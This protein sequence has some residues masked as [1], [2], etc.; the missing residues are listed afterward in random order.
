MRVLIL[1]LITTFILVLPQNIHAC[2]CDWGGPFLK[3]APDTHLVVRARVL[4]YHGDGGSMLDWKTQKPITIK[5]AMDVEVLEVLNGKEEKS[6]IRIWGDNGVMCRPYVMS[7]PIGT[8]WIFALHGKKRYSISICGTFALKVMNGKVVGTIDSLKGA[9]TE[10][11][12]VDFRTVFKKTMEDVDKTV[13]SYDKVFPPLVKSFCNSKFNQEYRR[14]KIAELK[15]IEL[16]MNG[17][18]NRSFT[19]AED[20]F[21]KSEEIVDR[22]WTNEQQPI[23]KS[24]LNVSGLSMEDL[25]TILSK[26]DFPYKLSYHITTRI[27]KKDCPG[28]FFLLKDFNLISFIRS[29]LDTKSKQISP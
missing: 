16:I 21:K 20:A 2:S 10:M 28:M 5:L 19:A 4:N 7:F 9:K 29:K 23:L 27:K 15:Y 13:I 26:S 24:E 6:Q 1:V 18:N 12:L 8:E 25:K 14:M 3:V 17:E 22:L 11:T